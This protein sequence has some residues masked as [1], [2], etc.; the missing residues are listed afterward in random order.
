MLRAALQGDPWFDGPAW[1]AA[2]L[3]PPGVVRG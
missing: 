2:A 3:A 1:A